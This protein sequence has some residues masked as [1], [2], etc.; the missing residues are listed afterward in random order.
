[1]KRVVKRVVKRV[2]MLRTH[3]KCSGFINGLVC[4]YS[5]AN[6]D[7]CKIHNTNKMVNYKP[8]QKEIKEEKKYTW[9]EN[10]FT[11]CH[12][13]AESVRTNLIGTFECNR[14]N[15]CPICIDDASNY[16]SCPICLSLEDCMAD[17]AN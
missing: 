5:A 15:Y 4:P 3:K 13:C 17:A 1:M 2:A 6:G 9:V 7:T 8:F 11:I 14:H 16:D 10:G 12:I